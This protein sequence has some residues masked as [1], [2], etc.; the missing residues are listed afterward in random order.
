[1]TLPLTPEML[2][3][4]YDLIKT[5]PPYWTWKLPDSDEVK[6]VVCG[7]PTIFGKCDWVNGEFTISISD[8]NVGFAVT[9]LSTM[10][11]EML[12]LYEMNAGLHSKNAT[13]KSHSQRFRR[14]SKQVCK[15]LGFD[16][17]SFI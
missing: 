15:W 6:F 16:P 3:A 14:L 13:P 12:H 8:K 2:E 11:H 17:K 7:D 10:A 1:M 5:M 4:S 9:L